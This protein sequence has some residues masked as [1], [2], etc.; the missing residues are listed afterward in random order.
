MDMTETQQRSVYFSPLHLVMRFSFFL[1][2]ILILIQSFPYQILH[3]NF[4]SQ[5]LH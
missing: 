2:Q 4:Q 5:I 3:L 1:F